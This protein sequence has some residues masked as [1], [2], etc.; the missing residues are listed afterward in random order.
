VRHAASQKETITED[1][2]R[3]NYML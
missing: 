3:E 1:T 2:H